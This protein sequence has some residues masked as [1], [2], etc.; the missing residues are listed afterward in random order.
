MSKKVVIVGCG[1]SGS[2]T[3]SKFC[4]LGYEV[5]V[6]DKDAKA[7]DQLPNSFEGFKIIREVNDEKCITSITKNID[8]LLIVTRND[9]A[10]VFL[11]ILAKEILEIPTVITR[12]YDENKGFLLK[13]YDI[14]LIYP[15]KLALNEIYSYLEVN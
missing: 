3:A 11:S 10:N 9:E 6:V 12:L 14:G 8:I 5:Y 4:N 15:S 2:E 13:N 1:K 7:F